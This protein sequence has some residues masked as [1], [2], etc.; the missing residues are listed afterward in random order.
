MTSCSIGV[1]GLGR[2][3]RSMAGRLVEDGFDV[4]GYDLDEG[5]RRAAAD[6]GVDVRTDAAAVATDADVVLTSLP[7]D[8]AVR[9]A[10][11]ASDGVLAAAPA[12]ALETSTINPEVTVDLAARAAD[13]GVTFLDA[14]V[15]G[16]PEAAADG[17]L[18]AM[19]GGRRDDYER[20]AVQAVLGALADSRFHV[21]DVGTGHTTKLV[22]N[23]MSM[24]TLL[25]AMEA[26]SLGMRRGVDGETLLDVLS[27]AGGSS[28]QFRKRLPRVLNRE[29]EPGFSVALA[30]KDLGLA[31][32][33]AR[34][35]D[36]A[37]PTTGLV[38]QLYTRA[39][40]HGLSEEDAAAVAKLFEA[41]DAPIE[42]EEAVDREFEG[43]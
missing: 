5:A 1:V 2:M 13:A 28:N 10:Y 14:P 40:Q 27:R 3:G 17:T 24:G 15:S 39:V 4:A 7:S 23:V 41:E 34:A 19:V 25:L 8:D 16:G 38:Y 21:G 22:N 12:V 33:A 35:S 37:M 26:V 36:H 18:T 29:F 11:A 9:A 32:D 43:Y 31:L 42:S 6:A 20:E 30:R